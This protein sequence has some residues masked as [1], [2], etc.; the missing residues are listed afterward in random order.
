MFT[1]S[2]QNM[3]EITIYSN[4]HN[5]PLIFPF[6][7]QW[8]PWNRTL[9]KNCLAFHD[10]PSMFCSR[11][12]TNASSAL[13]CDPD[14]Q[15]FIG[16]GSELMELHSLQVGGVFTTVTWQMEIDMQSK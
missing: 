7:F 5:V 14:T 6:N 9:W 4:F 12:L 2:C 10:F 15:I 8:L 11:T 13:F 16:I 3:I 1:F